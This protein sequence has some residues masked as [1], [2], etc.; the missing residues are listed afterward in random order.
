MC[1]LEIEDTMAS[2]IEVIL[3]EAERSCDAH[4]FKV[5]VLHLPSKPSTRQSKVIAG[6]LR[7]LAENTDGWCANK[8][9]TDADFTTTGMVFHFTSDA[10]RDEFITKRI[11]PYLEP[12]VRQQI[13]VS[14]V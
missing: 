1:A 6:L 2:E 13:S 10:K 14:K 4:T 8:G 11:R 5:R 9:A 7:V 12:V 3:S